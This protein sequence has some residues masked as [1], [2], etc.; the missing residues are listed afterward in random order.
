M[1]PFIFPYL[2]KSDYA[3]LCDIMNA[4]RSRSLEEACNFIQDLGVG[5][6]IGIVKAWGVDQCAK[7]AIRYGPVMD[8]DVRRLGRDTMFDFGS[9][10]IGDETDELFVE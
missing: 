9:L 3:N 10:V 6:S 4:V 7:A 8:T 2:P 5:H 1:S